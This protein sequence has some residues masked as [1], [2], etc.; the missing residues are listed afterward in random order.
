MVTAS[1]TA[2]STCQNL[3]ANITVQDND[4]GG[5]LLLGVNGFGADSNI[6]VDDLTDPTLSAQALAQEA[7]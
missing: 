2:T 1:F 6:Q 3:F 5:N 4:P 7:W